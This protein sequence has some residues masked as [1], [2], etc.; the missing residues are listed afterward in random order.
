MRS[1]ISLGGSQ[2]QLRSDITC[3]KANITEK[4]HP[5]M[6]F[7]WL[8]LP[9]SNQRPFAVPDIYLR[10]TS[11]LA[12]YRPLHSPAPSLHPPLAAVR[13]GSVNAATRLLIRVSFARNQIEKRIKRKQSTK[14]ELCFF[15]APP[16][17]LE[18]TTTRLTAACSTD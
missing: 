6:S 4:R 11:T 8:P 16:V 12:I 13:L 18:P 14:M 2:I 3:R 10:A 15:L 7:S 9:G 5:K 17:G 1:T